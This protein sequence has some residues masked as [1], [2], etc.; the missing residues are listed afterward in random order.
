[1]FLPVQISPAWALLSKYTER[2]FIF[3][4]KNC[5]EIGISQCGSQQIGI[6]SGMCFSKQVKVD[7]EGHFDLKIVQILYLKNLAVISLCYH[8][9]N[10]YDGGTV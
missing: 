9:A 6:Q 1:M 4:R 3:R 8:G 7:H 5:C 10:L 2:D